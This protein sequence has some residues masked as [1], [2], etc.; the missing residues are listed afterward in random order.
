M[1]HNS[2][3]IQAGSRLQRGVLLI[4]TIL[5]VAGTAV[6]V[7]GADE[8]V[9]PAMEVEVTADGDA[10]VTVVSTYDLTDEDERAAFESL[11]DDEEFIADVNARFANRMGDVAADAGAAT[12]REMTVENPDVTVS[13]TG[14]VGVVGQSV[15][16]NGLAA[17]DG[18]R[19]IVTEPFSSGYEPDRS[20]TVHTP[21]GYVIEE[22]E[23]EPTTETASSV[24]YE[25]GSDLTDLSV[26]M[27]EG[28]E[29][30]IDEQPGFGIVVALTALLT[31]LAL[32]RYRR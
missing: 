8:H 27:V 6:G 32:A 7:A 22:S 3:S 4:L 2:L 21:D 20:L 14:D 28:D 10:T 26:S 11:E 13:I 16:W 29:D 1:T 5:V 18:E 19:L 25:A 17:V 15:T 31:A 24:T 23:P 9:E 30:I 12:D